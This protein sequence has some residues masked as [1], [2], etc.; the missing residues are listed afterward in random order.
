MRVFHATIHVLIPADSWAD[1]C[2]TMTALLTET[3]MNP[4]IGEPSLVDWAYCFGPVLTTMEPVGLPLETEGTDAF[5]AMLL[6]HL[7]TTSAAYPGA[8]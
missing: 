7:Q 4:D 3:G 5:N 8:A 1:A 2:D 6:R